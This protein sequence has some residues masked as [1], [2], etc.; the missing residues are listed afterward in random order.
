MTH[1]EKS[2]ACGEAYKKC[3]V[4]EL[5]E[6]SIKAFNISQKAKADYLEARDNYHKIYREIWSN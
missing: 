2:D 3:Q 5:R 4:D 1:I 6:V